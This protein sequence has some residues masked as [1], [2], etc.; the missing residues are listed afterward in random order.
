MDTNEFKKTSKHTYVYVEGQACGLVVP[1]SKSSG[2]EREY[3]SQMLN[4]CGYI[5]VPYS[6][7]VF[8]T[9][10]PKQQLAICQATMVKSGLCYKLNLCEINAFF[11]EG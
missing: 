10:S 11:E 2:I 1:K 8:N 4:Y 6:Y 3:N 7:D 5:E 9:F